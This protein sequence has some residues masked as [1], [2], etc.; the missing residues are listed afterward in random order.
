[1]F[2]G[3]GV[4]VPIEPRPGIEILPAVRWLLQHCAVSVSH[5]Q[6]PGS[7]FLLQ[8]SLGPFPLPGRCSGE[9][10][11][12][13]GVIAE[14]RTQ[15]IDHP[16]AEIGVDVAVDQCGG[17]MLD[18]PVNQLGLPARLGQSIAMDRGNGPAADVE[19]GPMRTEREAQI[20]FPEVAIP[21]IMVPPH[22][23]YRKA[24]AKP[25]EGSGDMETASG[26]DAGIGKPEVEQIAVDEQAIAQCRHR[27]E[28]FEQCLL[29]L[30]W[31]G[32]EVSIRYDHEGTA[33]HGAKDGAPVPGVQPR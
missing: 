23:Y 12:V 20:S 5:D 29:S 3:N 33:Q 32:A 1:M 28:K 22:H 21:S 2:G 31:S 17:R 6:Q 16:Q 11:F 27:V 7:R 8:Q 24:A 10:G 13:D 14:H 26:N 9:L 30:R 25:G 15:Q 18:E 19:C 4:A